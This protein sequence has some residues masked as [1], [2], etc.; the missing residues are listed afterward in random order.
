MKYYI[1]LS[2]RAVGLELI[3]L[4]EEEVTNL[5]KSDSLDS[6]YDD[7][8]DEY[9]LYYSDQFLMNGVDRFFF[10]VKDENGNEV[11]STN[12]VNDLIDNELPEEQ[13][14]PFKGIKS[15]TYFVRFQTLKGCF[16]E[17]EIELDEPFDPKRLYVVQSSEINDELM[18]DDVYPM[19]N[20]Y[21]RK[22]QTMI[23]KNDTLHMEFN[24]YADEQYY[25]TYIYSVKDKDYWV[26]LSE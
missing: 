6:E 24:S 26:R 17:G 19:S 2:V 18:D 11:Y 25:D 9:D 5:L 1:E 8:R 14:S 20:V 21:Y 15:G 16:Y 7:M 13:R 3:S 22:K 10:T 12:N 4:T 23:P